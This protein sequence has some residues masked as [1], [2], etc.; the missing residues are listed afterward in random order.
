MT[1]TFKEENA[2]LF[3]FCL[4]L[5]LSLCVCDEIKNK[6]NGKLHLFFYVGS[7]RLSSV[8]AWVAKA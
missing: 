6:C 3:C 7:V 4:E 5:G 8:S 1:I 2:K